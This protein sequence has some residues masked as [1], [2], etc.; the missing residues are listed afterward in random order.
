LVKFED[1]VPTMGALSRAAAIEMSEQP[2]FPVREAVHGRQYLMS[3]RHGRLSNPEKLR[4]LL[5]GR[6]SVG[7]VATETKA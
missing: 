4:A 2:L 6:L 1:I 7:D 3:W 5:E